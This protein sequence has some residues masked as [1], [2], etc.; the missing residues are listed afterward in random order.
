MIRTLVI[1]AMMLAA[2]P[3]FA[4][5]APKRP[6]A[7]PKPVKEVTVSGCTMLGLE[8]CY[9]FQAGKERVTL[10]ANAGVVIPPPRTFIVA[11]GKFEPVQ[12]GFCSVKQRFHASSI[13]ATKRKCPSK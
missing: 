9:L 10:T 13:I 6:P 1:A 3:A 2:G 8:G 12:I 7:K 5:M 4:E 11:K